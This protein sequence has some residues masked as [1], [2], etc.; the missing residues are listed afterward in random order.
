[1]PV[2]LL[3][4]NQIRIDGGTQP[5][6][7]LNE[8]VVDQYA[9]D[10]RD[11][12]ELPPLTVFFD[13]TDYW[14]VDG[15]HR[16][17]AYA[18]LGRMEIDADVREG[19]QR[20]AV[21]YSVGA[22]AAHGLQR[23]NADKR[24]SVE[25]LLNDDEWTQW[26]NEAIA[27][28]CVV[29]PHTVAEVRQSISANAEI[30]ATR[31]VERNGKTYQQDTTNV[32][33]KPRRIGAIEHSATP[34]VR[35]PVLPS[36]FPSNNQS[37]DPNGDEQANTLAAHTAA[38]PQDPAHTGKRV[39]KSAAATDKL[40]T[41]PYMDI[42]RLKEQIKMLES[43]LVKHD[44]TIKTLNDRLAERGKTID[45]LKKTHGAELAKLTG[46]I[47]DRDATIE[48]LKAEL[49]TF[50][51]ENRALVRAD[52]APKPRRARAARDDQAYRGE[53]EGHG[54]LR[55]DG[56]DAASGTPEGNRHV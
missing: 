19:T 49:K 15:F 9:G 40:V 39:A 6:E 4:L 55:F 7:Q 26:S 22:N 20:D 36:P 14:L 28:V 17:N 1:M 13:G 37:A 29:S 30:P 3:K 23:T 34:A 35:E 52:A 51:T 21:L 47:A 31:I 11:G 53:L 24:R 12:A 32:G 33:K 5:R 43:D 27:K 45:A 18:K 48:R 50:K 44:K 38:K 41:V 16:Y 25:T 54:Q 56:F 2:Q 46:R 42:K 8:A 10:L